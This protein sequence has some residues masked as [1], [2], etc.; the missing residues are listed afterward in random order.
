MSNGFYIS[1]GLQELM[2]YYSNRL[3]Y[4]ELRGLIER[5]SGD[6][7]LSEQGIWNN[8]QQN[9]QRLSEQ[10]GEAFKVSSEI[11]KPLLKIQSQ[12]ELDLYDMN[13]PEILYFDDG[14]L[15]KAQKGTREKHSLAPVDP[16]LLASSK[17]EKVNVLSDV[18]LLQIKPGHFEYIFPPI[19][20]D[21]SFR[22]GLDD[23]VVERLYHHYG[24]WKNA[25]PLVVISDGAKVIR[26]RLERMLG[27][28]VTVILDWYPL[29]KKT[30]P[31]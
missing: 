25:L 15:V 14:I 20:A 7:L 2:A 23:F 30:M 17:T 10:I 3:S 19:A 29:C 8:V 9:V 4:D 27:V 12:N 11:V 6:E 26:Q 21:G 22:V 5:I 28:G 31:V 24:A 18:V 16:I 1:L 13:S